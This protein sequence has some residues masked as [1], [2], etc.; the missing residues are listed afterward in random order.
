M[1][2]ISSTSRWSESDMKVR[3]NIIKLLLERGADANVKDKYGWSALVLAT[4]CCHPVT[5]QLV[6]DYCAGDI[7]DADASF[8][9][10]YYQYRRDL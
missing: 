2:A 3:S 8:I 10:D 9:E 7:S 6:R 4:V 1:W 5:A